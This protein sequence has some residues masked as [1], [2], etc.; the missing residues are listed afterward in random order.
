MTTIHNMCITPHPPIS[1]LSERSVLLHRGGRRLDGI[2]F[3]SS[4]AG[5]TTNIDIGGRRGD[6]WLDV[7]LMLWLSLFNMLS[8]FAL[9]KYVPSTVWGHIFWLSALE[10]SSP[11]PFVAATVG[12]K[13]WHDIRMLHGQPWIRMGEPPAPREA[14]LFCAPVLPVA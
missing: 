4:H 10:L 14:S 6:F 2:N 12:N 5:G 8:R 3:A 9:A 11:A 13:R 1:M 7:R